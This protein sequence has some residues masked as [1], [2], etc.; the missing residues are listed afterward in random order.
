MLR[1]LRISEQEFH[2]NFAYRNAIAM[3]LLQIGECVKKLSKE[4][5]QDNRQIP[6]RA[7]AGMRDFFAHEYGKMDVGM[8]WEAAANDL[9]HV[10]TF[11]E[12]KLM[13]HGVLLPE[14]EQL[15]PT[16]K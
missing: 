7:I 10:R 16:G 14:P 1:D 6:W 2:R 8:L 3:S 13:E 9:P 5:R 15:I 11:C 12:E 4:F